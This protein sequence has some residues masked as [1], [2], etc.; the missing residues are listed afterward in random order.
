M[1]S[2]TYKKSEILEIAGKACDLLE[3]RQEEKFFEQIEV[4]LC[5]KIPFGKLH[6]LGEYLGKRGLQNSELYFDVL[7]K[8]FKKELNYGYQKDIYNTK[9]MRM[10]GEEVQKSRV[11]GW[12]AGIVG[13]AFNEMSQFYPEEV[14]ERTREYIILSSHWSSS[15]TFAD[16]TFNRMFEERFN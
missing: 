9:K 12:R 1:K 5:A 15:D 8:F 4:L 2:K 11:W 7:D 6:P 3:D 14:V 13:L 10:S 16:E